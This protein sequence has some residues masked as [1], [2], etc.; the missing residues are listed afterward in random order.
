[1]STVERVFLAIDCDA[2]TRAAQIAQL[3]AAFADRALPGKPT[4]PG[5]WHVTLRWIGDVDE[6]TLDHLMADLDQDELGSPFRLKLTGLGA[7]PDSRR[8]GVLWRAVDDSEGRVGALAELVEQVCRDL[9]LPADE[10][11]YVPHLTLS[12]LRPQQDLEYLMATELHPL[13]MPVTAITV[14]RSIPG[15]ANSTFE[16]LELIHLA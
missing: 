7:F 2:E 16:V 11:P 8:A 12:R 15:R 9:G 5:N 14:F 6:V 4:P 10:R 13:R 3:N 1:M